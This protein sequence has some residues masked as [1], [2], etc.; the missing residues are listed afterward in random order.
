MVIRICLRIVRK[1]R[2]ILIFGP[3]Q[4]QIAFSPHL[5]KS[6]QNCHYWLRVTYWLL[7]N[8][9]I[10]VLILWVRSNR[11][12]NGMCRPLPTQVAAQ[13]K[14]WVCG[15]SL[16]GNAGSIPAGGMRVCRECCVL[17]GRSLCDGLI[18]RSKE[19][20]RIWC[21]WVWSRIFDNE[22]AWAHW[23]V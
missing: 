16:F 3:F 2:I 9:F 22:E 14:A 21:V 13:F 11:F 15:R 1:I 8:F 4:Y 20:Y 17:S 18:T 23:G 7:V 6:V 10:S 19:S 5:Y 12:F